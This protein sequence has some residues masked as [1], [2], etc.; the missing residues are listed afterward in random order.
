[1]K[2]NRVVDDNEILRT[3]VGSGVHGI[4]IEGTDDHDE[5]G[6]FIEP[7]E[8]VLGVTSPLDH[9]VARTQPQGAR[10]GPGDV[11]LVRYS[12]RKYMRLALKG[13]PTVLL[14]L[15][16]PEADI[17]HATPYGR[18][19]RELAPA[20]ISRQAGPRFLGYMVAQRQLMEGARGKRP[21]R[22]ELVE[23]FGFDVKFA[24]H[25]LRLGIQGA[26][27]LTEGRIHLPMKPEHRDYIRSIKRGEVGQADV[28]EA[29]I[30][31]EEKLRDILNRSE[32]SIPPAPDLARVNA[33]M[34]D[35]HLRWWAE[36]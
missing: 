31:T 20:I 23:R 12:L 34:V 1:M 29:V 7:A 6:V 30:A 13:N 11:D 9:E 16:A 10:S 19:L 4:A 28:L 32:S 21:N 22:P 5:M 26:E 2:T 25:A 27:L 8:S 14:P 33:W 35:V 36:A 15:F 18:E 24:S 17:L 3:T